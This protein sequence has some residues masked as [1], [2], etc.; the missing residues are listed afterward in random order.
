[1]LRSGFCGFVVLSIVMAVATPVMAF[2]PA[3]QA[4][5]DA[6]RHPVAEA[7]MALE[8]A[9]M[10]VQNAP[11]ATV[12]FGEEGNTVLALVGQLT[13]ASKG[14]AE[15]I[16]RDYVGQQFPS[17]EFELSSS[18]DSGVETHV[19]F[20]QKLGG[21][22][23]F[24][25]DLS[26]HVARDGSISML[27][28]SVLPADAAFANKSVTEAGQIAVAA[29]KAL[30]AG[31]I[32]A[33]VRTV[34]PAAEGP[35]QAWQLTVRT[36]AHAWLAVLDAE[37][38]E[39]LMATDVIQSLDGKGSAYKVSPLG[40]D[41]TIEVLPGLN[42]TGILKSSFADI[43]NEDT[44]RAKAADHSFIYAP[45][46]THFDEANMYY[47][48][49]VIYDYHAKL[50]YPGLSKP[51]ICVVHVGDRYDNAYFSPWEGSLNFGDGNRL[52]DL[53]KDATV[54]YH[55]YA[56]A[57]TSDIVYLV[58]SGESGGLNEGYSDYFAGTITEDSAVGRYS[59]ARL[60][61]GW[62][63]NMDNKLHYPEDSGTEPHKAGA[64]WGACIWDVRKALGAEVSD[65]LIHQSRYYLPGSRATFHD[66]YQ[67]ILKADQT[68]FGGSHAEAITQAMTARGIVKPAASGTVPDLMRVI[69]FQALHGK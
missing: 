62:I 56:H 9:Q 24:G 13:P 66:G 43:K 15:Q 31:R 30:G 18:K 5:V 50:G 26:V 28:G 16:A 27:N 61:S 69:R 55:E 29:L 64:L 42:G 68:L 49:G 21:Q 39:V 58:Y 67:A 4:A 47:Y 44:D 10:L 34:Y 20:V 7:G 32:T 23:V 41:P 37:T 53:A 25:N 35:R 60:P 38:A 22:R 14:T 36:P 33:P 57:V 2:L 65:K 48:M 52:N 46:D 3:D 63:R 12:V 19:R 6:W 40:G 54:A 8:R 11:T 59:A 1:M 45:D 51:I 17:C